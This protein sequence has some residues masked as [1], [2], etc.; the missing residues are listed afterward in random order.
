M[1]LP[2][3]AEAFWKGLS[4]IPFGYTVLKVASWVLVVSLLKYYFGG[5]RN[6]AERLMHGKVVMVTVSF[7][8]HLD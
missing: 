6:T 4:S 8:T 5:A 3:L 7:S 1:P 2:I